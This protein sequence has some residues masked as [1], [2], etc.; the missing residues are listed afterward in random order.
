M[1]CDRC[2][3]RLN[4]A[5]EFKR[6]CLKS[7]EK[8]NTYTKQLN[9]AQ[10]NKVFSQVYV[11]LSRNDVKQELVD[12]YVKFQNE[13]SKKAKPTIRVKTAQ[14]LYPPLPNII[15][16]TNN[17]TSSN[18]FQN[19]FINLIPSTAIK[20][21]PPNLAFVNKINTNNV[22]LP[23]PQLVRPQIK[24]TN[25]NMF[26][27][28]NNTLHKILPIV[29]TSKDLKPTAIQIPS[30]TP[31]SPLSPILQKSVELGK[32]VVKS[33]T[34]SKSEELSVEIDPTCFESDEEGHLSEGN[35]NI[36]KDWEEL[37]S[38]N[39]IPSELSKIN[40]KK[41]NIPVPALV[42]LADA[43]PLHVPVG[44][45]MTTNTNNVDP[46][47]CTAQ[48]IPTDNFLGIKPD[49]KITPEMEEQMIEFL[50]V[51]HF[52][53]PKADGE[54]LPNY[55]V[56]YFTCE[57]CGHVCETIKSLK[58]HIKQFHLGKFLHKCKFCWSEYPLKAQ[59]DAHMQ[60]HAL[61]I[62][63][64]GFAKET[65]TLAD[66]STQNESVL[67]PQINLYGSLNTNNPAV[68]EPPQPVEEI[69][70]DN[71]LKV[72]YKCDLCRK[73]FVNYQGLQ[74]HKIKKH[75][76]APQVRKKYF[77]K[78]MKN[79][80]CDICNREFSTQSYLQLHI[81][82]HFRKNDYRLKVFNKEKYLE[83]LEEDLKD[84]D[85][86]KAKEQQAIS[87]D[88][89][90][91]DEFK[92]QLEFEDIDLFDIRESSLKSPESNVKSSEGSEQSPESLKIK[93]NL[94]NINRNSTEKDETNSNEESAPYEDKALICPITGNLIPIETDMQVDEEEK[95]VN[96]ND[97]DN[98]NSDE[99]M[100]EEEKDDDM[101]PSDLEATP[102]ISVDVNMECSVNKELASSKAELSEDDSAQGKRFN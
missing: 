60:K 64:E 20:Y 34:N 75:D 66:L 9:E 48:S 94:R 18:T 1:M 95:C 7:A 81:K 101:V 102:T 43:T 45:R 6:Q 92:S 37:I 5:F 44:I 13:E 61:E 47:T 55:T 96:G 35:S 15:L 3:E 16:T 56:R 58:Y 76:T 38:T 62:A 27:N 17:T 85:S 59:F 12:E 4:S 11:S 71:A 91:I 19:V 78:G 32:D 57:Q 99:P 63:E 86:E 39:K 74:H 97:N 31:L 2:I 49:F 65:I 14:Q 93:I 82:L 84:D 72:R 46:L 80:K 42:K 67:F 8:W 68:V 26:L 40:M 28:I 90:P 100:E 21:Q 79:A 70:E 25:Q 54:S 41:S 69:V 22:K 88:A 36:A 23:Q 33:L 77:I 50:N 87:I 29:T 51:D 98:G 89:T 10:E 83:K 73:S 30:I 52:M 24:E 53:A